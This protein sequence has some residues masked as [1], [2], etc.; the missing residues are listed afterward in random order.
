MATTDTPNIHINNR[1]QTNNVSDEKTLEL[2]NNRGA[3]T[4]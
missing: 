1:N 3:G 2:V 4:I